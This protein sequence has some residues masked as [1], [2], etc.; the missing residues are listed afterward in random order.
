MIAKYPGICRK[1]GQRFQAGTDITF[2]KEE[3]ANHV[4]CPAPGERPAMPPADANAAPARPTNLEDRLSR[5]EA[6]LTALESLLRGS[7]G[8]DPS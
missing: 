5:I 2:S 6:R 3:G 8:P 1:C 7:D 4:A